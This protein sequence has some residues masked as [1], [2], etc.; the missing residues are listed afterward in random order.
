MGSATSSVLLVS[1]IILLILKKGK[2]DIELFF[3]FF[4]IC[5]L[6]VELSGDSEMRLQNV[7]N[8]KTVSL[9][10]SS[11]SKFEGN[12]N[13]ERLDAELSGDSEVFLSGSAISAGI[14]ARGDS[15]IG[16]FSFSIQN[17]NITLKSDSEAKFTVTETIDIKASGDS[18]LEYTGSAIIN[19]QD[20]SGDAEVVWVE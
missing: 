10:L 3:R 2:P 12:F 1:G 19:S 18:K 9:D 5:L 20:L 14:E 7:L 15:E 8:A 6:N 13:T 4:K 17:L 11:D 16:D